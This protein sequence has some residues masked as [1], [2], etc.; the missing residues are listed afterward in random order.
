MFKFRVEGLGLRFQGFGMQRFGISG[1]FGLW[2][3]GVWTL[4]PVVR[5]ASE[6]KNHEDYSGLKPY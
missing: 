3:C 1:R 6:P 2:D 5:W 4:R